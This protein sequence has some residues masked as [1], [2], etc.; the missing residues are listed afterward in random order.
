[1][2]K[3]VAG[4]FSSFKISKIILVVPSCGPSSKVRYIVPF[5]GGSTMLIVLFS[6]ASLFA[7][8]FT[9]YFISYTPALFISTFFSII[10][11]LVI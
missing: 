5:F 7:L 10:T 3:N 4:T 1:M 2:T 11:L 9:L 6:S 8:S